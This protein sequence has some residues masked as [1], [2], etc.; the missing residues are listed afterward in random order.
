MRTTDSASGDQPDRLKALKRRR[1]VR[2]VFIP[3]GLLLFAFVGFAVL[4]ANRPAPEKKESGDQAMLISSRP[5]LLEPVQMNVT[6]QGVVVPRTETRLVAEVAGK[7]VSVSPKFLAGGFFR[8]GD[9]LLEIDP[10]DYQVALKR[11]GS[12]L[13]ANQARLA[14]ELARAEQGLKDWEKLDRRRSNQP[15]DL[16]LRKPQLAE[17]EAAVLFAEADVEKAQ[18]DLERTRIRAPYDALV[19]EKN[20]DIGQFVNIG[21]ALGLIIAID[22]AE[23]RL[24]LAMEDVAFLVLH[25]GVLADNLDIPVTLSIGIGDQRLHRKGRIVRSEGVINAQTRMQYV[26]ARIEDPYGKQAGDGRVPLQIGQF[27]Q[28]EIQG[29]NA[30]SMV[31]LPRYLL[32]PDNSVLITRA[33]RKLHIAPVEVQ[34]QDAT[35]AYLSSGLGD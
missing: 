1:L 32:R 28:A 3:L 20:A 23:V 12:I 4:K 10:S 22:Y 14:Q 17:A 31:R 35:F 18:R 33:D 29:V 9:V 13:A 26:V 19:R 15:S 24:P 27:V 34:R 21:T 16:V 25:Q 5:V 11:S 8:Q 30:D 2:R 6:S 7:I